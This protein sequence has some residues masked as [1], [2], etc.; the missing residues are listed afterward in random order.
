MTESMRDRL[1]D[2]LAGWPIGSGYYSTTVSVE[3][4]QDMADAILA[5]FPWLA[6]VSESMVE[7]GARALCEVHPI[8]D[9]EGRILSFEA[10]RGF[11]RRGARA[12][13][14]AARSEVRSA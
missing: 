11:Y 9:V 5:T 1:R 13:L 3:D 14:S 8:D 12:V 6:G 10:L 4:A 7:A 2:E